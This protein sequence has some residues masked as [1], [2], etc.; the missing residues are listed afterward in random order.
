MKIISIYLFFLGWTAAFALPSLPIPRIISIVMLLISILIIF[1]TMKLKGLSKPL[2][3][4]LYLFLLTLVIAYVYQM[5]NMGSSF[6]GFGHTFLL[7]GTVLLHLVAV[8]MLIAST[9]YPTEKIYKYLSWGVVF[10]SLITIAEFI[11][12]NFLNMEFDFLRISREN[13]NTYAIAGERFFR[14]R[15][16]VVE[17]GHLSMYLLMFAPFVY[18]YQ[19]I[20][21]KSKRKTFFSLSSV[22]LAVIFT[23]SAAGFAEIAIITLALFGMAMVKLFRKGFKLSK[24]ILFYPVLITAVG[25]ILY[26]FFYAGGNLSLLA[27]VIDKISFANYSAGD[28]SSRLSR[29]Q[30]AWELFQESPIIGHGSGITSI[31]YDTGSTNI[32]LEILTGSGLIGL[33]L[34]LAILFYHLNL[35]LKLKGQIKYI[36][37]ISFT[38]MFIHYMAISDYWYPW[39]WMLLVMVN[40]QYARQKITSTETE[41]VIEKTGTMKIKPNGVTS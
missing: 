5:I 21:N 38:T 23:F 39:M 26:Y 31:I 10:V 24:I 35:I 40:V 13:P 9:R 15:G 14:A 29:W 37:L 20:I 27:G 33:G 3:T 16:T 18:Y 34:F 19:M 4:L 28:D 7:I 25:Y 8:L 41:K 2:I 32:Y 17:S 6:T 1:K 36:Y 22:G 12:R 30:R 11:S